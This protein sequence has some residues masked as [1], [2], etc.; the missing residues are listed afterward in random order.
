MTGLI[1]SILEAVS[2]EYG[3][4]VEEIMGRNREQRI[5]NA[6][7]MAAYLIFRKTGYTT[8]EIGERMGLKNATIIRC[9]NRVRELLD[10]DP[11]TKLHYERLKDKQ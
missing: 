3:V 8:A 1:D 10:C 5:A 7:M 4:S 2:E 11:P 6:R 9:I